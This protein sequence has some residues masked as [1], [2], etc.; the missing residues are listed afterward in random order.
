ML[1][2]Y[3]GG[4]IRYGEEAKDN[5]DGRD[6]DL[7]NGAMPFTN[8]RRQIRS[9]ERQKHLLLMKHIAPC[10][11]SSFLCFIWA[12]SREQHNLMRPNPPRSLVH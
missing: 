7:D 5:N 9:E 8:T 4:M 11:P 10:V 3:R 12:H 6:L 1:K 2:Q